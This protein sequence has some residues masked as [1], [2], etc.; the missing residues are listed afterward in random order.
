[1]LTACSCCRN[2]ERVSSIPRSSNFS[3]IFCKQNE[4]YIKFCSWESNLDTLARE[5]VTVITDSPIL[6]PLNV[7]NWMVL[8]KQNHRSHQVANNKLATTII[9]HLPYKM[10]LS[11]IQETEKFVYCIT[12]SPPTVTDN[13]LSAFKQITRFIIIFSNSFAARLQ[14]NQN[15][16]T[17]A[18]FNMCLFCCR[19]FGIIT[20]QHVLKYWWLQP[21]VLR[22]KILM[23]IWHHK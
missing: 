21:E 8:H 2:T 4:P 6:A 13:D 3:D 19:C 14:I 7:H 12:Y 9:W 23:Y 18:Y 10:N 1:M 11:C 16:Q 15:Y 22:V 5:T 20:R 17:I